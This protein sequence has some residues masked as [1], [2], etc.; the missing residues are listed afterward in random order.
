MELF[1]DHAELDGCSA[2]EDVFDF[3]RGVP[4]PVG[5]RLLRAVNPPEEE[6]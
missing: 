2:C 6:L 3:D 4:C 1:Q 5:G